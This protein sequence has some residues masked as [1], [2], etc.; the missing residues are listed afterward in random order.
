MKNI[1]FLLVCPFA[2]SSQNPYHVHELSGYNGKT[3]DNV[4]CSLGVYAD[5]SFSDT[6]TTTFKIAL[7]DTKTGEL[8][9]Q[10]LKGTFVGTTIDYEEEY[11]EQ[12]WYVSGKRHP[13]NLNQAQAILFTRRKFNDPI[14]TYYWISMI[15]YPKKDYGLIFTK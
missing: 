8:K 7:K 13:K 11:V 12:K 15:S 5:I 10:Y 2:L 3:F 9:V 14:H 6:D 1:L 4:E